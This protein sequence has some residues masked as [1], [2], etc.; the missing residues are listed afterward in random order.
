[1]NTLY[2]KN[3][4]I[5][6]DF[7]L[8][9]VEWHIRQQ[10]LG[11]MIISKYV[12][13]FSFG[14]PNTS[15]PGSAT[16]RHSESTP[17]DRFLSNVSSTIRPSTYVQHTS[18]SLLYCR[19]SPPTSATSRTITGRLLY[20]WINLQMVITRRGIHHSHAR[21]RGEVIVTQL[22]LSTSVQWTSFMAVSGCCGLLGNYSHVRRWTTYESLGNSPLG[23][24]KTFCM[25][26]GMELPSRRQYSASFYGRWSQT[27]R[28]SWRFSF[29]WA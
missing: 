14:L 19:W 15:C 25:C 11:D 13:P 5:Y 21:C 18:N 2:T 22:Y 7:P 3:T 23:S 9:H 29:S 17:M 1:M 16:R 26:C 27:A 12:Y 24:L 10:G 20:W 6:E 28:K 8:T 4:S